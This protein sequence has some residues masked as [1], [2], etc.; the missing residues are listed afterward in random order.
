M[1]AGKVVSGEDFCVE[2][3]RNGSIKLIILASDAGVNTVKKITDKAS[4]YHV[5]VI[6]KF[7]GEELSKA[8][9]KKNRMVI[10]ITDSG[11]AKKLK[12]K[13]VI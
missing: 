6:N 5:E 2:G 3:I 11:F 4:F 9:G 10:G 8:I 13:S 1:R 7:H 12:E